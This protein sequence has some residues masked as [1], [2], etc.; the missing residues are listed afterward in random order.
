MFG[1]IGTHALHPALERL[2]YDPRED[3]APV[4]LIGASPTLL[5]VNPRLDV[6]SV[7]QLVERLRTRPGACS[8]AAAGRG[9][10]PHFAAELFR[11]RTGVA[12][13]G[14]HYRGAAPAIAATANGLAQLMFPSLFTAEP[15]IRTGALRALAVAGSRRVPQLPDLPTLAELGIEGVDVMQWYALFAPRG[16]SA[17]V[18][19]GLSAAH[20]NGAHPLMACGELFFAAC[21]RRSVI[22]Q[23]LE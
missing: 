3:F 1:Y 8:Y 14:V 23:L 7:P 4:G 10:P 5:V 2:R 6:V 18:V 16:T 21:C 19:A 22:H 12:L 20:F 15:F 9:T 17:E 13:P 11:L